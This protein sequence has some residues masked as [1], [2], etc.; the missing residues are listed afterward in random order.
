MRNNRQIKK[1]IK[2]MNNEKNKQKMINKRWRIWREIE[3][4]ISGR[5]NTDIFKG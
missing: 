5:N 1:K 4:K 2:Q 3:R